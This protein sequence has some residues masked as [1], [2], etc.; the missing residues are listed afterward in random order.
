MTSLRV[1]VET[2]G[3]ARLHAK[4]TDNFEAWTNV[5]KGM[6]LCLKFNEEDNIKARA[7][8]EAAIK[9]DPG[10]T[11]AWKW[12]ARS[13]IFDA[14]Y[15]WSESRA[16][17]LKRALEIAQKALALDDKNPGVHNTLGQIYRDQRQIEK[18]TSEFKMA[19]S[20][21]PNFSVG[22]A[23]LA[24]AMYYM[25]EFEESITLMKKAM[26]LRPYYPTWYLSF[27][28]RAYFFTKRYDEA[29]AAYNQN[30]DRGRK[31][32]RPSGRALSGLASVYIE[33]GKLV[34]AR[35]Y[36]AEALEINPR[37]SLNFY[38][39]TQPFKNPAHLQRFLDALNKAGL[40]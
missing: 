7:L 1:E 10:Y 14:R 34:E 13:H 18:A 37:L 4:S 21:D 9:L 19:I 36:M 22:Y 31:E 40:K 32:G 17:S 27:L 20:L 39:K 24:D 30:L 12:L 38:K 15:G 23:L 33:L 11:D 3:T 8:F 29:I 25:G 6:K 16:A 35:A 26:R 2:G 28:A 5:A